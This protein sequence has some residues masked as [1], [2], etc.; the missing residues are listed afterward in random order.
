M[1]RRG[2][3]R[4]GRR[5]SRW[6]LALLVGPLLGA[7]DIGP[8]QKGQP[9]IPDTTR[10]ADDATRE[11]LET[12]DPATG[13]LRFA[14]ST[15]VLEGLQ[16]GD[17]LVSQPSSTAPAGFLRKVE[18]IAVEGDEVVLATSQANLTDAVTQGQI[19]ASGD[20]TAEQVEDVVA[21]LP[22]VTVGAPGDASTLPAVGTG[23]GYQFH[24]GFD[25]VALDIGQGDVQVKVVIDG[26]LHFNAGWSIDLG[27]EPCL[28]VPPVCVDRFEAKVGVDQRLK[29]SLS[30]EAKAQLTKEISVATYYFKPLVFFIGPVPVVVVPSIEVF[31]GA[32]GSVSLRFSYGVTETAAAVAGARWT[33]DGGWQDI[34]DFG[35]SLAE[36]DSFQLDATMDAQAYARAVASLKFYDVAGPALGLRLGVE[37]D[38]EVPRDPILVVRG[39][40][41]GYV[42]F[43]VDLP[44]LGTL[45]EYRKTL[46]S[47][48]IDLATSPNQPPRFSG[49]K[50]DTIHVDLGS[51]VVLGPRAGG[52]Q[53]YFDVT[54]PEG[55]PLQLSAT[56]SLDG[57]IPLTYTFKTAGTRT[58]EVTA[59]DSH[60]ATATATLTVEAKSPPPII[61]TSYS[62]QPLVNVPY[63]I[64]ASA[65]DPVDG[66]MFCSAI[67]W[68]V[69]AP[70]TRSGGGCQASVTFMAEG[71]RT[72]R[73]TATNRYGSSST[74][75]LTFEVGPEPENKPPVITSFSIIAAEG[76]KSFPTGPSDHYAC[77]TGYYCEVPE[78]AVLWNGQA[79]YV[80]DYVLP[81]YL[82][83]AATDDRGAPIT[84]TWSC[85]AGA[86]AATVTDNGDGTYSCS[87]YFPG[88]TIVV[89][90]VVSD[91][92]SSTSM[93]RS[94]YMRSLIN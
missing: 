10:V 26:E 5:A 72:V 25:E 7:C 58:I 84:V 53:G 76:P 1:S 36:Q 4:T 40:I 90:V 73:V 18:A 28:D 48:T 11:A 39:K 64:A 31:V 82:S 42:A 55:G 66:D 67:T 91:G 75:T 59:T 79:R 16:V 32:E 83:V 54:D 19:V 12:Y 93:Q 62:G 24:L 86:S 38:A 74:E 50:T 49:V 63:A 69:T 17:V 35:V 80:G 81:L 41:E 51:P 27:I 29:V 30:G 37:F 34:T 46:F 9:I 56:S 87:P 13:E 44:V 3:R 85:T 71:Q 8:A 2:P 14:S 94:F 68:S 65:Y 89:K 61:T 33:D 60:G 43:V 70:D 23:D 77:I 92:N 22:G 20:F 6:L 52:F 45:D 88:H 47:E 57:R 15:P 78:G 21:H